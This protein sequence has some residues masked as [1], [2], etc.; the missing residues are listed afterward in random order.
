VSERAGVETPLASPTVGTSRN[1]LI[2]PCD[3]VL[4]ASDPPAPEDGVALALAFSGGG[5]RATLPALGVLRFVAD[6]GLLDRIRYVSSV[7]GG[8]LA[9]GLFAHHYAQLESSGFSPQ[10]LDDVVIGPFV[11]RIS[12]RS[13][14]RSLI[15]NVWRTIGTKTRTHLLAD[16]FDDW[17]FHGRMLE[18]LSPRCRFIVNAA[19]VTTGVRFAFE[20]EIVGDWVMGRAR[21][22]GTRIR[23]ATAVAASAA[24]PGAFPP[25]TVDDVA[26]PCANGRTQLLLDGGAYDNSG[27]EALDNVRDAL[28]VALN[29]GGLFH[30]G[31]YGGV[32]LI[33]DLQR[34]N[35]L[36]YRQSTALRFRDTV[37]RFKSYERARKEGRE[38]PPDARL[39]VLFGLASTIDD[40]P[41]EWVDTRDEDR[42]SVVQL[43]GYKTSFDEFPKEICDKL[44][45][46][47]WWLAGA[48]LSAYHRELLPTA[49]PAWRPPP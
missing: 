44:L 4:R 8:S 29:A 38:P 5:F 20:R 39:G 6:A 31:R 3:K 49:L 47:G 46:R 10:S 1:D 33:R 41:S 17:F 34:A 37:A 12:S 14:S 2:R 23:L 48:T 25:L 22:S 42:D 28:I 30:T 18:E 13:L 36:L 35:S 15:R 27:I 21:T 11:E 40:V 45:Y 24:V 16:T 26:F 9:N 32:P 19:S 43:A 7:S